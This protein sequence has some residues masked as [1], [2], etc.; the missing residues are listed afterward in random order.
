MLYCVKCIYTNIYIDIN[1][2]ISIEY[3]FEDRE[4]TEA[5]SHS[6]IPKMLR[7]HSLPNKNLN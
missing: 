2:N 5:E 7:L 4:D 1:I 3:Q 6:N